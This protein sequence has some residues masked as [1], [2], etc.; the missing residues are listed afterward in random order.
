VLA[1]ESLHLSG[2]HWLSNQRRV[3]G[4]I[5]GR[6]R[7]VVLAGLLVVGVVAG[8]SIPVPSALTQVATG[9]TTAPD[10]DT[11]AP[12][13]GPT[14]AEPDA[15]PPPTKTDGAT[16]K[17]PPPPPPPPSPP[18]SPPPRTS[19]PTAETASSND[20]GPRAS[21]ADQ[22]EPS[23]SR[24]QRRR[25]AKRPRRPKERPAKRAEKAKPAPAPAP[26]ARDPVARLATSGV[27]SLSASPVVA[28]ANEAANPFPAPRVLLVLAVLTMLLFAS[29]A[30]ALR[31]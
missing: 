24:A 4:G 30:I 21:S 9:D 22:A 19:P 31:E 28:S 15:A 17:P 29:L 27:S 3:A 7:V 8:F 5:R 16:S 23:P 11:T 1:S 2:V 13:P 26:V 18:P 20:D 14:T 10:P 6:Y 25:P 12:D